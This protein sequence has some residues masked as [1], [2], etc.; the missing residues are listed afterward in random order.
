MFIELLVKGFIIGIAFIIP[1]VSGGTLAIYLG[2]YDKLLHAL[3]NIFKEFKK[4]VLF[5]IPIFLGIGISVVLLA[6]IFGILIAWNSFITLLFF[7]G[8]ILGGIPKLYQEV[9]AEKKDPISLSI[10]LISFSIVIILVVTELSKT[11]NTIGLFDQ[12][13]HQF[14]LLIFLGMAASITMIVPGV[15]GSALLM[16]LGYYTAI[17]SNVI[18]NILDFTNISY[19]LFVI[20]PFGLGCLIGIILFS[21][22]LEFCLSR[23]KKQTYYAILGFIIA[24]VIAIFLGIKDPSTAADFESQQY[25][26]QNIWQYVI[27]NPFVIISGFLTLGFGI[28]SARWLSKI[29]FH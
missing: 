18:G 16:A 13:W 4:S 19:H 29:S 11:S 24:S 8:L 2:V 3:G 26:Y 15:S 25:I 17:V 27:T 5:L 1:G 23:Y 7:I 10:F 14:L 21:K 20:I 12:N 9:K 22:V 28:F 6:K